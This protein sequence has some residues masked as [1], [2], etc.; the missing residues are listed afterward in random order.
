MGINKTVPSVHYPSAKWN[1]PAM[2]FSGN[3][4]IN[5]NLDHKKRSG[6]LSIHSLNALR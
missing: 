5:L 2:R 6:A 4:L 3:A 1:R